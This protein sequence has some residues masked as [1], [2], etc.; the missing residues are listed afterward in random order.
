VASRTN[1]VIAAHPDDV[2]FGAAGTVAMWSSSGEET[3][4]CIVTDG[5][6][7]G[8]DPSVPRSEIPS[9]RRDEQRAAAL[10]VGVPDVRFL[11][12]PDG[13]VEATLALRRDI[14]RVIRQV[15]PARVVCPSPERIWDRLQASH[16]DHLAVGAAA[17][18]AVYPDSRNPFA[19]PELA[20]EGLDAHTVTGLWLMAH[21]EPD[22]YVDI[23]ATFDKKIEALRCHVSQELDR[24]ELAERV[25]GFSEAIAAAGGMPEGGR[26]EA[27]KT[28]TLP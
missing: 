28:I 9:I 19:F 22:H 23:S 8:F 21:P 14:S 17:V 20:G 11:G 10:T 2:D 5:D 18:A 13:Q 25:V 15:R 6:A 3:I 12:Y 27:F 7:G 26:A 1:L 4:Y 16:P 24:D